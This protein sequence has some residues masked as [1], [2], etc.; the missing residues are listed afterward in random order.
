[1]ILLFTIGLINECI[2]KSAK[3]SNMLPVKNK[4]FLNSLILMRTGLIISFLV[5]IG[6][7]NYIYNVPICQDQFKISF[8][9]N[10]Y[11]TPS[12]TLLASKHLLLTPL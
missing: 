8:Y 2:Y 11:A 6:M 10:H 5:K 3:F 9:S 12:N 1:M 7:Y 4:Y